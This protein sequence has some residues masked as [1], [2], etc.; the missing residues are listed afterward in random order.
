M[1]EALLAAA[2]LIGGCFTG[3]YDGPKTPAKELVRL[4]KAVDFTLLALDG[5]APPASLLGRW[6]LA[7]GAHTVA[8]RQGLVVSGGGAKSF[9]V[10]I[11]FEAKAG[12]YYQV[13][14]VYGS[15]L[16]PVPAGNESPIAV[17]DATTGE[18]WF[19]DGGPRVCE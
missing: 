10:E 2:V 6:T 13:L 7:P 3:A 14:P 4:E 12:H 1:R 19:A 15:V 9:E 18:C 5:E 17:R 8:G 11:P 16:R